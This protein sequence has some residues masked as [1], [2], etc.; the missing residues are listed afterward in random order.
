MIPKQSQT[1]NTTTYKLN[2]LKVAQEVNFTNVSY[3][4]ITKSGNCKSDPI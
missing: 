2:T 3:C 4:K 1:N